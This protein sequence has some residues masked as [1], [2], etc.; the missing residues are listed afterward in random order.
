V[1]ARVRGEAGGGGR[2]QVRRRAWPNIACL[3]CKNVIHSAQVASY[4][5][6]SEEFGLAKDG[7]RIDAQDGE[8]R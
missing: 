3:P 6:R 5:R 8:G 2:A 7:W 4:F 1:D